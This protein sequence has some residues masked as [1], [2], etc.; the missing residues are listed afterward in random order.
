MAI[1]ATDT[2]PQHWR[3]V[4]EGGATIVF[5]YVGPQNNQ[6]D[7]TVLRLRKAALSISSSENTVNSQEEL[8]DPMIEF[9]HKCMERLIPLEHLPR[10]E[11]VHV[12][13]DWLE[14]LI[15]VHD[16][17]RPEERRA[18]DQI[19]LR[20]KKGVLAT[21]LVGGDWL[22]V[23]IKARKF[24]LFD[25]DCG[26]QT[27][28]AKD[29]SRVEQ[30]ILGLWEA[31]TN[32]DGMVNNLKV[33]VR[34]QKILPSQASLILSNDTH[35]A[36]SHDGLRKAFTDAILSPL[37]ETPVLHFL[38]T[39]QRSLDPLDI[40]G[41]SKLW[42]RVELAQ[43]E[44][45]GVSG[46]HS[47]SPID[48]SSPYLTVN[49]PDI[50]DW[51]NFVDTYLSTFTRLD[52]ENPEPSHLKLYLLAYLLSATFKDCSIIVRLDPLA[53]TSQGQLKK[54]TVI[55]LDPKR[56][57]RLQKW[58]RLDREIVEAYIAGG[59][60]K[61]VF[62]YSSLTVMVFLQS[63]TKSA[64]RSQRSLA[65]PRPA[66]SSLRRNASTYNN[67]IAGL[68][69]E[70]AEFRN[71]IVDFAQKEIAPKAA[72]IDKTNTFP[73]DLWEKLGSMGLLGITVASKYNGLSLGYLHHTLA[74][75][76]LSAA[77]GHGTDEQKAK[78]LPDLIG[79]TKVGSLAMSEVT[80]GSDVVS[81]R[82][83]AEKVQGG[84]RLNGSK[85]WI[86][87]GPVA[88]TL[89]VYAKTAPGMG[90][91]GITAFIV[92]NGFSGFSTGPKLDKFGM[93]GSDTG[94]LI[95]EDCFVPDTNVLGEINKGAAV[96]MSGLDLER[97]VLS[98]G[99]LGLMQAAF[100][101]AVEYVHE[102]KQFGQPIGTFQLMQAKIADMYT[103]LNAS[104]SYVYAVARA[105][106]R[107]QVSRRDCAGAILY[108]TE[109]AVEVALEG[110]QCFGGNGYINDYPMGRIVRDSRL[111]TVGAGTQEIRRMLIGREFNEQFKK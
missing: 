41:L 81:M 76:A 78:Y 62:L 36:L 60:S 111:Y 83:K 32:S 66:S 56:L 28:P 68:T 89:V 108:S 44:L 26:Q 53:S 84:W 39:L 79:G 106:D 101:E 57:A 29:K 50:V 75:E 90:S 88:S 51:T 15:S 47:P 27:Y 92:E 100:D 72:E 22:S 91:K 25:L 63:V 97:I 73:A 21:D 38:S 105:C 74:M 42:H 24:H 4:S 8:D 109:R 95:F 17:E 93:R 103:K 70:E 12:A 2:L 16:A 61:F 59:G 9:Q 5:S 110:M 43:H 82:L 94:E 45:N 6:F 107:G 18:K 13:R 86:T 30:A 102:R 7:G 85:F 87:N 65:L 33:F 104:R 55:D 98:G 19:D 23:E 48:V 99:P 35:I 40:E 80:S 64:L 3:Y 1:H 52:H 58:E 11:S 77:S 96:L 37:L 10:L 31:W 46:F 69:E 71:V 67:A 14:S 20:R 49:E 34:G 54:V